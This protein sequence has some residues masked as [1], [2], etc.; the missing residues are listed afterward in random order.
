MPGTE[1]RH[2]FI[3][4][5]DAWPNLE[6]FLV[7]AV[8]AVLGIRVFLELA[9]YPRLGHSPLHVAHVLWGGLLM[10]G[11]IIVLPTFLSKTAHRLA[12]ALAGLG[13][14]AFIDE[15]G[16]FVTA[17]NNYFYAP[18]VALMYATFVLAALAIHAIRT[19]SEY[20]RR[21]YLVRAITHVADRAKGHLCR[22][23]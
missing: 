23:Y 7:T 10:L 4:N 3:R 12:S 9:G 11:A 17:D 8:V 6:I 1:Q 21:E 22:L 16:K 5:L 2:F 20:S 14:G 18:A 19:R 13:F 15:V